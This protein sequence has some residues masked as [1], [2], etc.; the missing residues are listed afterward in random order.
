MTP[1]HGGPAGLMNLF[2]FHVEHLAQF[3]AQG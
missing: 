2:T 1:V 3:L